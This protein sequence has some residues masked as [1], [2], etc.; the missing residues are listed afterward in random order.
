MRRQV[1]HAQAAASLLDR[2]GDGFCNFTIIKSSLPA[3]GH[4]AQSASQA[5]VA[6]DFTRLRAASADRQ[7]TP[8]QGSP[9]LVIRTAL[10]AMGRQRGNR[11]TVLC[12]ADGRFEDFC[13]A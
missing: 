5:R 10:P 8:A 11:E 2:A 7:L 1:F 6:K 3:L 13:Y 9:Q 4:G 12:K